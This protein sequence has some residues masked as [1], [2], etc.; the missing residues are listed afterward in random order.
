MP[1]VDIVDH[2]VKPDGVAAG[3]AGTASAVDNAVRFVEPSVRVKPGH[4]TDMNIF[5]DR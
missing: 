5:K 2:S 1:A 3:F 4:S